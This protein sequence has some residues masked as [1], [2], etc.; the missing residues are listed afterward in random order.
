MHMFLLW[1]TYP[2]PQEDINFGGILLAW[3]LLALVLY[4]L[5]PQL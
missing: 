3:V 5:H 4:Y 2:C 1:W